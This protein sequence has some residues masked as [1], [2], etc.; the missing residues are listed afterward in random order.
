M[1]EKQELFRFV[2]A[3]NINTVRLEQEKIDHKYVLNMLGKLFE[4]IKE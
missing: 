2:K 4:P 3:D 1:L